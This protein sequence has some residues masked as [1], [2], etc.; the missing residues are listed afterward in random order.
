M[1]IECIAV[2]FIYKIFF[3]FF[4]KETNHSYICRTI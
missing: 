3:D 4:R 1:E 2:V